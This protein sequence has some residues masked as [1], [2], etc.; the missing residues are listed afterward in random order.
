MD[1]LSGLG[2]DGRIS[3]SV[4]GVSGDPGAIIATTEL[5]EGWCETELNGVVYV[6]I[7]ATQD[8]LDDAA[9]TMAALEYEVEGYEAQ[10]NGAMISLCDETPGSELCQMQTAPG[11]NSSFSVSS[12]TVPFIVDWPMEIPP[13]GCVVEGISAAA[14]LF[15]WGAAKHSAYNLL[16]N[17]A[18]VTARRALILGVGGAVSAA[19]SAGFGVG[20]FVSCIN[21]S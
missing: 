10:Y 4:P 19:F 18:L 7:C 8:D 13:G 9:A 17:G 20:T 2:K 16:M 3:S 11:R 21:Q 14:G 12:C 6:D 5:E 15:G 1:R